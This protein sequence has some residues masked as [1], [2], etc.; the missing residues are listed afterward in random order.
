MCTM[1]ILILLIRLYTAN[2][3]SIAYEL[4]IA[5]QLGLQENQV[6]HNTET[7]QE[8]NHESFYKMIN[9]ESDKNEVLFKLDA[10]EVIITRDELNS[11]L[12]WIH[13]TGGGK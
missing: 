10:Q 11:G 1:L 9:K 8:I 2:T 12:D 13:L 3:F 4:D 7:A 5:Y 6:E